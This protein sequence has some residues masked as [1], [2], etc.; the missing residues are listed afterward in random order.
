MTR[1]ELKAKLTPIVCDLTLTTE[2]RSNKLG[3]IAV[4]FMEGRDDGTSWSDE[5]FEVWNATMVEIVRENNL[6]GA[7]GKVKI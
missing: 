1:E 6:G 4:E 7:N 5:V 3:P 2:E